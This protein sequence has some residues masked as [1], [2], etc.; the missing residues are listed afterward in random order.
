MDKFW[1]KLDQYL[2]DIMGILLPGFFA[3]FVCCFLT[4][5]KVETLEEQAHFHFQYFTLLV[6]LILSFLF[7][8]TIKHFSVTFYKFASNWLDRGIYVI[9]E[10][11]SKRIYISY[12]FIETIILKSCL[13]KIF[14]II[15]R[16][17]LRFIKPIKEFIGDDLLRFQ[18]KP[19][20]T[21]S[22]E[23][24]HNYTVKKLQNDP[25]IQLS[26]TLI[27]D[28]MLKNEIYKISDIISRNTGIKSLW[29]VQLA[30]YNC[31][32]SFA[33]IFFSALVFCIFCSLY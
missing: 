6:Y 21:K 27:D 31:Y 2:F 1:E 20:D 19:Y 22:Y 18:T 16:I 8:H 15:K 14:I 26:S 9:F 24:V 13:D 23:H 7:G 29:N 28:L 4:N 5:C 33:F 25:E 10:E 3:I 12:Q 11:V 30:K 32:R 17:V